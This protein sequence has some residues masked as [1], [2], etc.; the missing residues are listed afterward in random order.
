MFRIYRRLYH[1]SRRSEDGQWFEFVLG[2][3]NMIC[4]AIRLSYEGHFLCS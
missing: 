4:N 3:V 1:K 2:D